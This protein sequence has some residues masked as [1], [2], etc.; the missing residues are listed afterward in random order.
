M[1]AHAYKEN[2]KK[3]KGNT[4][5]Y[6]IDILYPTPWF[7][8]PFT[9]P[10]PLPSTTNC[11]GLRV[12]RGVHKLSIT[13]PLPLPKS[14]FNRQVPGFPAKQP[15]RSELL[16]STRDGA[17]LNQQQTLTEWHC[18][19]PPICMNKMF[20]YTHVW[21]PWGEVQR[22]GFPLCQSFK[23]DDISERYMQI[24]FFL[25]EIS[26]KDFIVGLFHMLHL[27]CIE[28]AIFIL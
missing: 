25:C 2:W 12:I 16:C 20:N 1:H 24:T 22:L 17:Q 15:Q 8:S 19:P 21:W 11:M 5:I 3:K 26:K 10:P 13:P 6:T 28:I 27:Q 23:L 18:F 7:L 14:Q 4:P 9:H